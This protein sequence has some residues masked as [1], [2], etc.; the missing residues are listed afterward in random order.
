MISTTKQEKW[1]DADLFERGCSLFRSGSFLQAADYFRLLTLL[2]P[3]K[4]TY[5]AALGHALKKG[6]AFEQALPPYHAALMLGGSQE[7][8]LLFPLAETY[9]QLGQGKEA[10]PVLKAAIKVAE[11]S[12]KMRLKLIYKTWKSEICHEN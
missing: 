4:W 1:K 12:L 2:V 11:P 7:A 5:Y 10:L 3:G 9:R 8:D 6:G